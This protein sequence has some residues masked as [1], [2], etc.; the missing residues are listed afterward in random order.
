[1]PQALPTVLKIQPCLTVD[2]L[3]LL[4]LTYYSPAVKKQAFKAK[5]RPSPKYE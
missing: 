5:P 3:P 2:E 1:M 4:P